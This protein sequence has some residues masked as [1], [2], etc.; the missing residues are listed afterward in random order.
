ML[1]IS[2]KRYK[3]RIQRLISGE[4]RVWEH[5]HADHAMHATF[6][7]VVVGIVE[8]CLHLAGS[9]GRGGVLRRLRSC[10]Y[11]AI[12]STLDN[13]SASRRSFER[14]FVRVLSGFLH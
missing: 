2:V 9:F 4:Q 7:A 3:T 12:E 13:P 11:R 14:L 8:R 1:L 5:A 10:F 6:L